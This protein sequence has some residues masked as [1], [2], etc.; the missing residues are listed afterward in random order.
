MHAAESELWFVRRR[1]E[2]GDAL[3]D[4][5][6]RNDKT[7]AAMRLCRASTGTPARELVRSE[8]GHRMTKVGVMLRWR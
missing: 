4:Y 3:G 7:R 8:A 5:V 2:R 1:L 6:G